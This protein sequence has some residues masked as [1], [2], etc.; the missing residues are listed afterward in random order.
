MITLR[1]SQLPPDKIVLD[2]FSGSGSTG[3]G[4]ITEGRKFLGIEMEQKYVSISE[5]R[6]K[7]HLNKQKES[8]E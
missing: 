2:P 6:I 8:N 3:L 1:L 4:A 7:N 5:Q